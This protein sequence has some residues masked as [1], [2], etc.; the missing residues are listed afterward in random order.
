[1][2]SDSEKIRI[3]E[4]MCDEL[5]R[6]LAEVRMALFNIK[7]AYIGGQSPL[8]IVDAYFEKDVARVR[9]IGE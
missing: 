5:Q 7:L 3:L 9:Q 6:Q 8:P 2:L 4:E 1:M